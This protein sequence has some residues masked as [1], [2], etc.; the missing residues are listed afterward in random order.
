MDHF[1]KDEDHEDIVYYWIVCVHFTST[2][3]ATVSFLRVRVS[4]VLVL[5]VGSSF[6]LVSTCVMRVRADYSLS[7]CAV[8]TCVGDESPG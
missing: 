8:S 2:M 5:G 1:D 7:Q 3:C 6:T 4:D